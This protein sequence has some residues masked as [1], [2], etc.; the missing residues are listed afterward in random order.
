MNIRLFLLVAALGL[1]S[2]LRATVIGF[3]RFYNPVTNTI[4]DVLHDIH[5]YQDKLSRRD[6]HVKSRSYIEERLF[7]TEKRLMKALRKLNEATPGCVDVIW[8]QG[9]YNE[10]IV[11]QFIGHSN[12][13]VSQQFKGLNFIAS[14][15]TR[16]AFEQLFNA[17]G[18]R[19][20]DRE[21][22]G[23]SMNK[24]MPLPDDRIAGIIA[25]SGDNAWKEYEKLHKKTI[26]NLQGYFNP[27]YL[28]GTK[29]GRNELRPSS[30]WCALTDIEMLSWIL[31]SNKPHIIVYAGGWHSTNISAFLEFN[32]KL[33]KV[34]SAD[35]G[36]YELYP[37]HLD[38]LDSLN[39][40]DE[41][42]Y[43]V[44]QVAQ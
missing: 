18:P 24:P 8:E 13:L 20:L 38:I 33:K 3:D 12:R 42:L 34:Y 32:L 40:Y 5:V 1:S 30:F 44:A 22:G 39:G 23:I 43:A 9:I 14:D 4:I 37:G 19:H 28:N 2:G 36:G 26:Q 15:I 11:E 41:A 29:F 10:D 25:N 16:D 6:F 35:D 27:L 7:L 17:P 21:V 31:S